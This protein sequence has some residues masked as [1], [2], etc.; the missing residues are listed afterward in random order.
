MNRFTDY[1][2]ASVPSVCI[3][4]PVAQYL[5]NIE[6]LQGLERLGIVG[7]LAAGILFFVME[8]RSFID[9]NVKKLEKLEKR[10][11][12]LET[13]VTTGNDKVVTILAQ[14]LA[15]LCEIKN[16]QLEN[17]NRMWQLAL[18]GINGINS[19]GLQNGTEILLRPQHDPAQG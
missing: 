8:R 12:D 9:K 13:N 17:F 14:Q 3:A 1:L 19:D 7:F 11:S 6:F 16:G 4:I 10:I 5:P 2:Y 18:R 15:T